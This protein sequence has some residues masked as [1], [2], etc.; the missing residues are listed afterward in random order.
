MAPCLLPYAST[1]MNQAVPSDGG[2]AVAE[3][4]A[5]GVA[6]I[7]EDVS[8]IISRCRRLPVSRAKVRVP[9]IDETARTDGARHGGVRVF[10]VAEGGTATASQ[11][12]YSSLELNP[13]RHTFLMYATN[14]LIADAPA[15]VATAQETFAKEAAFVIE[16]DIIAG[17][18]TN[19]C[20]G[21]LNANCLI[22]VTPE[23]GQAAATLRPE[24]LTKMMGRLWPA[25]HGR[26][27]WL[28]GIDAYAQ[29]ADAS[30]SNGQA[31]VQHQGSRRF[32]L[33]CELIITEHTNP[34]GQRG[35]VLLCDFGEYVLADRG[36]SFV[37]SMHVAYL[38]DESAFRFTWRIDGQPKWK[39]TLT[40]LNAQVSTSM[41]VT[42]GQR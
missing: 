42:L 39:S 23:S 40:P 14:E 4:F 19:G 41:A 16:S 21:L 8:P 1:G 34:L 20:F 26:A 36:R 13:H 25:C 2:F 38:T 6:A 3:E 24:N 22:E 29:I 33:G 15:L 28:M 31:I 10:K 12:K 11:L 7:I 32:I 18:G 9:A 35:D 27:I 17:S 5:E 37:E 30:F